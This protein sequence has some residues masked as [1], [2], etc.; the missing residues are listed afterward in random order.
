MIMMVREMVDIY[1]NIAYQIE[2]LLIY[3]LH[4]QIKHEHTK[5]R[6]SE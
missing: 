6:Q 2:L 4:I 1:M 3:D 5:Q